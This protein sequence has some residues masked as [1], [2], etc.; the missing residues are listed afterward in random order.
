MYYLYWWAGKPAAVVRF[1][2]EKDI[3][4]AFFVDKNKPYKIWSIDKNVSVFFEK[5]IKQGAHQFSRRDFT[6]DK[7]YFI[8]RLFKGEPRR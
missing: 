2:P 3:S 6:S 1:T 8:S 4:G 5:S 7:H